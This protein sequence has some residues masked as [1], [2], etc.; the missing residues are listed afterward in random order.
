MTDHAAQGTGDSGQP[1]TK[2][3]PGFVKKA[4]AVISLILLVI[5]VLV[6]APQEF[7]SAKTKE[8]LDAI[9]ILRYTESA[10]AAET[11]KVDTAIAITSTEK[12]IYTEQAAAAT[13]TADTESFTAKYFCSNTAVVDTTVGSATPIQEWA[14]NFLVAKVQPIKTSYWSRVAPMQ[15]H[16]YLFIALINRG[17]PLQ[18]TD[19]TNPVWELN[20]YEPQGWNER[21]S[22]THQEKLQKDWA[23]VLLVADRDAQASGATLPIQPQ[24]PESS[25]NPSLPS[26]NP[27]LPS[28]LNPST[29]ESTGP[30]FDC[31]ELSAWGIE[32]VGFVLMLDPDGLE[33]H[34]YPIAL[35]NGDKSISQLFKPIQ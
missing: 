24:P 10:V 12:P 28:N 19:F 23:Y 6:K 20:Q 15:N 2:K 32:K 29:I 30:F 13:A 7:R 9:T 25:D 31:G 27:G 33:P 3:P 5:A 16:E 17:T 21:G 1:P 35:L 14:K 11:A 34:H 18:I 26:N 22:I 8:T 4:T